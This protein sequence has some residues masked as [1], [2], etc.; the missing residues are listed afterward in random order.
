MNKKN[1]YVAQFETGS[2][3]NLLPLAAGQLV[4]RLKTEEEIIDNY[5]INEIIFRRENPKNIVSRM[6][7]VSVAGL[8][9]FL[10]NT[11]HS[12]AVAKEI[13]NKFSESLV[14]LGGPSIPKEQELVDNFLMKNDFVDVICID[15]GEEVFTNLCKNYLEKKAFSNIN[16]IIYRDKKEGNFK[17]NNVK[18]FIE[19]EKL[20]SPYVDG[21]FEDFYA[22]Y[23]S[24]FSG[25]IMENNRGCPYKCS[26]C[27][28]GNQPF[29]KIR[30]K[31]LDTIKKEIDWVGKNKIKYI[32]MADANFG[33]LEEDF[34]FVGLLEQCKKEY[35]VPNFISVSWAKNH[36][37]RILEIAEILKKNNIESRIT[38][39][40]QSLNEDVVKAIKR[41][42]V[43]SKDYNNIKNSYREN[44]LYSYTELIFGLP[45]EDYDSYISGIE[46]SLSKSVFDQLYV[47][48]LFLFPNTEMSSLKNRLKYGIESRIV[49]C[50]YTKSKISNE[51]KENVEIVVGNNSMPKEK[52]VDAFVVGYETLAL[53]DNRLAFFIFNY[54]KKEFG[55]RLTELTSFARSYSKNGNFPVTKNSFSRLENCALDVQN[56]SKDHLI[57]PK[58]YGET[59]FD[60]PEGIFLELLLDKNKFYEEFF[61]I[62]KSY[63][64]SKSKNFDESKLENLFKF[65]EA[66]IASPIEPNMN[67]NLK[68]N[69]ID[70]FSFTFNLKPKELKPLISNLRIKDI[71]PSHDSPMKFLKNHFDIRGVP[72][73][74]LLYDLE[75]KL[76]FPPVKI[77]N[78][79]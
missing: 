21:T 60:P 29:R 46:N 65:Q 2:N 69:W 72:A 20:P 68:Y 78:L 31:S 15:E 74:N 41:V 43:K 52:W 3:I 76:V 16:G 73:F 51:I 36:S 55:T 23:S 42:N 50:V 66:V 30:K 24:Y 67:L 54:L 14:V 19:M 40:L 34:N 44:N 58:G 70:Y 4:S 62:T 61:D 49:E 32:A 7:E 77:Q 5:N 45:L 22:K 1:I 8:S 79:C 47:Y 9:C 27:T 10:W 35:G 63:L 37:E 56:K 11:N 75:G 18:K 48:P 17:R 13:K 12:L 57:R 53:H 71:N 39:S 25:I 38:L 33:I 64:E 28:W 59:P 26:Y 6:D